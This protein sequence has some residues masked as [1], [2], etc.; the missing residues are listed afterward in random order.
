[1]KNYLE[2]VKEYGKVHK[3]KNR[4]T[5][6]C[7]AIA[8]FLVTAVF[9]LADMAIRCQT[10]SYIKTNGDYHMMLKDI[11]AKTAE[12]I[13]SRVE[14]AASGWVKNFSGKDNYTINGKLLEIVGADESM[15]REM[16]INAVKGS[17]P[18]KPD[19]GLLDQQAL[20]QFSIPIGGQVS[21][22]SPA[23]DSHT[24]KIVGTYADFAYLKEADSHGLVLTN[25]GLYQIYGN[26]TKDRFFV[27]FKNGVNMRKTIDEIKEI[28]QLSDKQVAEN[29]VLLGMIGQSRDS[30]MMQLY[31]V[32]AVL[33][34]LVLIA[35]VLMIAGSFNMNFLERIQFFGLLRC[36]GASKTQVKKYV[37]YEGIRFSFKG[38]PIGLVTGTITVWVLC[39][40]LKYVH[41][42]FFSEM[43]LFGIS[44]VSLTAGIVVGFLTVI[45]A[46]LSP[47]RKA[48]RVSP[49]S[50]VTGNI[51]RTQIPQEKTA[52]N[53]THTRVD[54]AMGIHHALAGKKNIILMTGSFAI[55]IILFLSFSVLVNF[56]HQALTPVKP[57]APDISIVS[58][59]NTCSLDADLYEKIKAN[60][61]VKRAYGRMFAYDVPVTGGGSDAKINLISYEENQFGWAR[62]ELLQGDVDEA[63][64]EMNSVLVIYEDDLDWQLGDMITLKLAS[65]EKKVKI[66]GILSSSPFSRIPGT[67]TVICSEHTFQ[68]LTEEQ[69]YTIIDMQLV[70]G[71]D[72]NTVAQ[73]RGLTTPE[74]NFSDRRQ[75]NAETKMAYYSFA[76]FV[77][78]FL[79]IIALITVFNIINSMNN[80]VAVRMN[81]Y[82]IMRAVGMSYKQLHRMVT[83]E[84]AAYAV[85]GCLAGCI[86]GLPLHKILFNSMITYRWGIAWQIP[87][88][89]I[90]I[91][92]GISIFVTF[93]SVI[94]PARKIRDMDIVNVV[95]AH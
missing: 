21:I 14:V 51:G 39:A 74:M 90:M 83:A 41:P 62:E 27:K 42:T 87:F 71:A 9:G 12:M 20:E 46:S 15:S 86:L 29:T 92:V 52:V 30:Y 75:G 60:P 10:I 5:I 78:G 49:L 4:I 19:E 85:C 26:N 91:I 82:G 1:M 22:T 55:S 44:V 7:I 33:F 25:D 36:L 2:L 11:D 70:R 77:Y 37:L 47:C 93:L 84:A 18:Q 81:Q 68:Q 17:Y 76:I 72:D 95:N 63:A 88:T 16:G 56:M 34:V 3:D 66:A 6:I 54:I 40:F 58:G 35:G 69:G 50:A 48:A 8:V 45:L 53:T 89:A 64:E 57:Y 13:G 32:A 94:R 31:K 28:Y 73:I 80:S 65:G 23:G 24:I 38:I 67:Q 79:V 61:E 59:D 43:P